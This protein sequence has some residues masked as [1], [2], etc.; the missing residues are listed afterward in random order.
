MNGA[1]IMQTLLSLPSA[2]STGLVDLGLWEGSATNVTNVTDHEGIIREIP[3]G[4]PTLVGGRNVDNLYNT[5]SVAPNSWATLAPSGGAVVEDVTGSIITVSGLTLAGALVNNTLT[6]NRAN[7]DGGVRTYKHSILVKG[8][9]GGKILFQTS[10]VGGSGVSSATPAI[11]TDGTWQRIACAGITDTGANTTARFKV[12]GNSANASGDLFYIDMSTAQLEDISGK[13]ITVPSEQVLVTGSG[14]D[15]GFAYYDTA[16]ANTVTASIVDESAQPGAALDPTPYWAHYPAA[17]NE[18]KKCHVSA[19]NWT[20]NDGIL[21]DTAVTGPDGASNAI[22][23]VEDTSTG[24]HYLQTTGGVTVT[25]AATTQYTI[26]A[27]IKDGV[28][29]RNA[30]I[31]GYYYGDSKAYRAY[32]DPTD[33]SYLWQTGGIDDYGS[34]AYGNGWYRCWIKITTVLTGGFQ[35]RARIVSGTTISYA[36]DGSSSILFDYYQVE[37]GSFP[38]PPI[39]TTGASASRTTTLMRYPYSTDVFNQTSGFNY[40][41]VTPT[42]AQADLS[43]TDEGITSVADSSTNL[44]TVDSGLLQSTDGTNTAS[45]NPAFAADTKIRFLVYFD[46]AEDVLGIGYRT[47]PGGT[48]TWATEQ[49]YDDEFANWSWVNLMFGNTHVWEI[50]DFGIMNQHKTQA[51]YEENY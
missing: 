35:L 46:A 49:A 25:L 50:H 44:I 33:G 13:A 17:T 51:Y 15:D 36:G 3:A 6:T 20:G 10:L 40:I 32:F 43:A 4:V 23:L 42:T 9:V 48:F 45:V 41:D 5:A 11:T 24:N 29:T 37:A 8:P 31:G 47:L 18:L 27:F 12:K 16:N 19:S 2:N 38:T 39:E 22:E 21:S 14:D 28:G 7:I 26:S 1:N 34:E 30:S